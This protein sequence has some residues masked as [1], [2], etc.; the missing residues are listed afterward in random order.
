MIHKPVNYDANMPLVSL[1]EKA[2]CTEMLQVVLG[3]HVVDNT[4]FHVN[5][6]DNPPGISGLAPTDP[7]Y[8]LEEGVMPYVVEVI[9]SPLP[10][11]AKKILDGIVEALF[12][13]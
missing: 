10:D 8:A 5:T 6:G 12:S 7:M 13:K 3:S 1:D 11:S 9:M 4:F 2:I